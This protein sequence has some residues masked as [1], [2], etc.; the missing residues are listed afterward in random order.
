M[1]QDNKKKYFIILSSVLVGALVLYGVAAFALHLWPFGVQTKT[2]LSNTKTSAKISMQKPTINP[3]TKVL[4]TSTTID[5]KEQGKCTL[6]L[7]SKVNKYVLENSTEGIEGKTGCLDWNIGT[8]SIP[9]G[10]Y[11]MTVRFDGKTQT[12][13]TSQKVIIP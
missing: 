11:D 1:N 4:Q 2:E 12:S 3:T 7:S 13:S 6:T 10:D 5:T 8:E 9:A